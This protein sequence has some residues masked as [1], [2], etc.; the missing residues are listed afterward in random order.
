MFSRRLPFDAPHNPLTRLLAERAAQ[1]VHPIDLTCGN[2]T[3]AL[4]TLYGPA[5]LDRMQAMTSAAVLQYDPTP[6]GLPAARQ[7]I[8]AYYQRRNLAVDPEHL[9]L[10]ASTSEAYSWL[11]QLLCDPGDEVL[12]PRP[13][14]PLLDDLGSL[15]G[16]AV[17][18]YP[19]CFAGDRFHIEEAALRA[20][21]SPR[22][23]ALVV[24]SPNNPTGTRLTRHELHSVQDLCAQHDLALIVDEVFSDYDLPP[25]SPGPSAQALSSVLAAQG[26][27]PPRAL[28]IVLSG[29]S[30]VLGLP[31]LKLGW[32]HTSGA[33]PLRT[34]AQERLERVADTFLSVG[35][36]VQL[37]AAAL[38][39]EQS[40]IQQGICQRLRDNWHLLDRLLVGT[41]ISR[42]PA[43]AGWYALL[44]V[45]AVQ[46]EEAWVLALL[47]QHNV[48][49]HPGYFFDLDFAA[50]LVVSLLTDPHD[51][52]VGITRMLQHC[53]QLLAA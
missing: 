34:Q 33:E 29:F 8:A 49:C 12:F 52:H 20:R 11:F 37:A 31:Q 47:A 13:S 16:V 32:I 15:A 35:T 53:A 10:S 19:L 18:N 43:E 30:K 6:R 22:T 42:V 48:L 39:E 21:L 9:T 1:G 44:R 36:P 5:L 24:V 45:P 51:L 27:R 2:P 7:A 28:T 26:D 3:V 50:H 23:R 38:L 41:A 40:R 46:S 4:P 25:S 14:Y 17:T